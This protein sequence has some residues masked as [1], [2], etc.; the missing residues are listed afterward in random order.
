MIDKGELKQDA[1]E[2]EQKLKLATRSEVEAE[3]EQLAKELENL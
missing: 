1:L 2:P 3:I